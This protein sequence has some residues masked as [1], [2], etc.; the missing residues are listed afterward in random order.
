MCSSSWKSYLDDFPFFG[1][2]LAHLEPKLQLFEVDDH[3]DTDNVD[4]SH[5]HLPNNNFFVNIILDEKQYK[6]FECCPA[7]S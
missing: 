4:L 1:S 2:A 3:G 6:N 7:L 5:Y